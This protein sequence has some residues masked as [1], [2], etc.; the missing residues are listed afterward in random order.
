M[1][2]YTSTQSGP[3]NDPNTWGGGGFPQA[4]G[5]VFNIGHQVTMNVNFDP[6]SVVFGQGTLNNNGIL[7]FA[8]DM[9]TWL[10]FGHQDLLINNGGWLKVGESGLII[11]KTY[12]AGISWNTTADNVKGLNIAAGG[13]VTAYGDPDLF[14][15]DLDTTLLAN[16]TSGKTFT[17]SGDFTAKWAAG[18]VLLLH[19]YAV[20]SSYATDLFL[21]TID[22]MALSGSDT[23]VTI[24]E[25]HPG[26]T[27]N[28][29]GYVLNLSRNVVLQKYGAATAPGQVNTYRPRWA[30]AN[31]S[32]STNVNI[33]DA[34]ILGFG[35]NGSNGFSLE[36]GVLRNSDRGP[37]NTS[38][39]N[40]V[41]CILFS[42]AYNLQNVTNGSFSGYLCGAQTWN[43]STALGI[44]FSSAKF[45]ANANRAFSSG[46]WLRFTDCE[47]F[48]NSYG[49]GELVFETEMINTYIFSHSSYG[50][51]SGASFKMNGGAIGYNPAGTAKPNNSDVQFPTKMVLINVKQPSPLVVSN[52]NLSIPGGRGRIA[53]EHYLQVANAHYVEDAWGDITKVSADGASSRPTQRTGG[54]ADVQEIAPQSNCAAAT[55]LEL[56]N[57]RLWAVAGASKTYRFYLQTDFAALA[58]SAL[59]LYG[60]YLD[61]VSGGHL[62]TVSSSGAGNFTT[63]ANAEDWSQY[64]EVTINPVQ[65]GYINLYLR[66]MGYEA[67]KKVWMDPQPWVTGG[68]GYRPRWSYGEI[69]LEP[70]GSTYPPGAVEFVN[71]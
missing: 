30:D 71:V 1:A 41:N 36:R 17:I 66:L 62:A 46:R 2:T 58:K 6:S 47:I 40:F 45:Y 5:D 3:W 49:V 68:I 70:R 48:S 61:Q 12:I 13:K 32:T 25:A 24:L 51:A 65:D 10:P 18:Q 39:M 64:V 23:Q 54:S 57:V 22:S 35:Q 11:P 27:F 31:G 21:G 14:G 53:N 63:R 52:R 44:D 33:K 20:Y 29:G 56:F 67:G 60:D 38:G 69:I 50:V 28:A 19:K 59:V 9:S 42:N 16:W 55:Y 43:I 26:G 4:T 15:S 37:N 7:V 8:R 34:V